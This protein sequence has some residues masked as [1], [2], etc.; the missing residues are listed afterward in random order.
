MLNIIY[1]MLN[2]CL[3]D[4]VFH[5]SPRSNGFVTSIMGYRLIV[6]VAALLVACVESRNVKGLF[7]K[8][9]FANQ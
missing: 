4:F 2:E 3:N 7:L 9:Y 1:H 8:W 5:S 6:V